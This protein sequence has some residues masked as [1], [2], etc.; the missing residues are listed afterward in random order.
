MFEFLITLSALF[1]VNLHH[2]RIVDTLIQYLLIIV[3][4]QW[5]VYKS[6]EQLYFTRIFEINKF[7]SLKNILRAFARRNT[8]VEYYFVHSV[9]SE[10][11]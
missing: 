6:Y 10:H 11:F 3:C 4:R 2:D 9:C 8:L 7:G 5:N 1:V